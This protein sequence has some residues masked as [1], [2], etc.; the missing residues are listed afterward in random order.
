MAVSS[1]VRYTIFF[2]SSLHGFCSSSTC[3]EDLAIQLSGLQAGLAGIVALVRPAGGG[4]AS[5]AFSCI[6][7]AGQRKVDALQGYH[8]SRGGRT[9]P[10]LLPRYCARSTTVLREHVL[11]CVCAPWHPGAGFVNCSALVLTSPPPNPPHFLRG[12]AVDRPRQATSSPK[13]SS[14]RIRRRRRREKVVA[15]AAAGGPLRGHH[16][17]SRWR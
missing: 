6:A 10:S 9:C 15:A 11:D 8:F 4:A 17:R 12:P 3:C 13:R 2:R 16:P 7:S 5:I 14:C 1:G